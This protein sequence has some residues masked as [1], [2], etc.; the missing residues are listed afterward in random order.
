MRTNIVSDDCPRSH[1]TTLAESYAANDRCV[2][3]DS[4]SFFDPCFHRDPVCVAAAWCQIVCENGVWTKEYVVRHVHVLPNTDAIFDRDV[5]ADGNAAF[6]E[7][8]I[9]DVAIGT[10][11]DVLQHMRERPDARAFADRICFD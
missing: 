3:A 7:R 2:G 10:D 5:V 1:E 8:V 4:Y 9:T 6:N 11:L